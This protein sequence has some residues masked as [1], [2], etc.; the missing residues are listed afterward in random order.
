MRTLSTIT[1]LV[2]LFSFNSLAAA[3]DATSAGRQLFDREWQQND[4][5]SGRGDG[6]GPMFNARSCVACHNQGGSGGGGAAEHNVHL[7]TVTELGFSSSNQ[8][9]SRTVLEWLHPGFRVANSVTIHTH[10]SSPDYTRY[11]GKLLGT[12]GK[13]TAKIRGVALSRTQ[14]EGRT[15]LQYGNVT[16]EHSQRN[17]PSLF[18]AGVIDKISD[19]TLSALERQ[20]AHQRN[21]SSVNSQGARVVFDVDKT[22]TPTPRRFGWKGQ[23]PTLKEFV[24]NACANELGLQTKGIPQ[25]IDASNPGYHGDY[26]DMTTK[27]LDELVAYVASLPPPRHLIPRDDKEASSIARGAVLFGQAR[28]QTCHIQDVESAQGIYSDL[29]LHEMG[30]GLSDPSG[31][32]LAIS[33][34]RGLPQKAVPV[35]DLDDPEKVES[36]PKAPSKVV[37]QPR[38]VSSSQAYFGEV[39]VGI[40]VMWRT[41][42]LWGV[43]DSAPYMHDGRAATLEAAIEMHGGEAE[44]SATRY[45]NMS[46][47]DRADLV[48]F[49][50]SLGAP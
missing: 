38:V 11:R 37:V 5:V 22:S 6:L 2:L 3:G 16:L 29:Q 30:Q 15:M 19:N 24:A 7:L 1:A 44:E 40:A 36:H 9:P 14:A 23:M 8:L 45:R 13:G 46:A 27:Q 48:A 31:T 4:P 12:S 42:P 41:P 50:H 26:V 43:R 49:V 33:T 20:A 18:G 47:A 39:S 21:A 35:E 25:A 28:C 32:A 17:T 34:P 10:G